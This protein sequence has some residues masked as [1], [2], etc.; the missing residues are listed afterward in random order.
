MGVMTTRPGTNDGAGVGEPGVRT[1]GGA[2]IGEME[3]RPGGES[4]E[5]GLGPSECV[6]CGN[7]GIGEMEALPSRERTSEKSAPLA[8][9]PPFC[10]FG[11]KV[12]RLSGREILLIGDAPK[13]HS[14]TMPQVEAR[15]RYVRLLG[16]VLG[17]L[18]PR[19]RLPAPGSAWRAPIRSN[20]LSVPC[21]FRANSPAHERASCRWSW[22]DRDRVRG[23]PRPTYRMSAT[24]EAPRRYCTTV[25]ML[26]PRAPAA[27]FRG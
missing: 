9:C 3:A 27:P 8:T 2:K 22:Q 21:T 15:M 6:G 14:A 16:A 7:A 4:T 23:A 11:S 5:G 17:R 25:P 10:A 12:S 26:R 13:S 1:T 18:L 19:V 20:A 24:P